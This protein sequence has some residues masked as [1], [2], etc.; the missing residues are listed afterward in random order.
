MVVQT[1][2]TNGCP[3]TIVIGRRGTYDTLQIAFDLSYLVE[4]YGNGVAVL[5]VKRSQDESAYPAVVTQDENILTW[6]VSETDTAYV[7]AGE[8]QLM[9]YVD[10]GLAKTIIYPMAVM[11]DILT[12]AEDAPDPYPNWIESLTALGAETLQ[13]AQAAAESASDAEDAKNDAVTAKDAAEAALEEFTT[14]TASATTLAAGSQATAEYSDGNFAFGIPRGAD[15]SP[16]TPGAPGADGVTPDFSIGTV[17][18]LEPT[19]PATATITGTPE[20]PV[21]NLGIPKGAKGD[22]GQG[23]GSV[24]SVNGQTGAVVL[25]AG[26]LEFDDS[27]TYASGSVGAELSA[28]KNAISQKETKTTYTTLS[29]TT[30]TQTGE[31]H[32]MYLCGELATLSFTAPQTG[33]TAIRFSSGTTATV[34]TLTGIT[35]P[36]D[37][38]GAEAST[39]Y[40]INVLNGLGVWQSWT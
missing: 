15:G 11:R 36:D 33:I 21:L 13:H 27:E 18:T 38:T 40:E 32:M 3:Q 28:Q 25:D 17:T 31:D 39:T 37:W 30:V 1:I 23:G 35:M 6:T 9:W 14:P 7:G 19:Q 26:D 12:T 8:C 20:A 29:G 24:D 2:T 4:S 16:G 34:V 22:P 10:G 5:A